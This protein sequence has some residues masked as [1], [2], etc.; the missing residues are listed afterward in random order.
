MTIEN[1]VLET[2]GEY[3]EG[4]FQ[5]K[6]WKELNIDSRK[7]SR[8]IAK[9]LKDE[10]IIREPAVD[11]GARTFLLRIKQKDEPRFELLMAGDAFSPCA[12][13]RDACQPEFCE[14]LTVWVMHLIDE[15]NNVNVN[16]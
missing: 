15:K 7:C 10:I 14:K 8:I 1:A 5:N 3:P 13:C 16:E 12:G 6:L 2:I 4:I 9:L 11:N